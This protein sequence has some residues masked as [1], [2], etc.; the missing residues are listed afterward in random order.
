MLPSGQIARVRGYVDA[1]CGDWASRFGVPSAIA[2]DR[3]NPLRITYRDLH[4][5]AK[6]VLGYAVTLRARRLGR[7]DSNRASTGVRVRAHGR[8]ATPIASIT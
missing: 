8:T 5:V 7:S 4:L 6:N 3:P 1:V 2:H